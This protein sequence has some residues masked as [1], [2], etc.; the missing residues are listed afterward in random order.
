MKANNMFM[1]DTAVNV[2][3]LRHLKYKPPAFKFLI[4]Q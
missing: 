3:L 4:A 2:Y 1:A